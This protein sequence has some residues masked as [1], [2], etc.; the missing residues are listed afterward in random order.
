[1]TEGL[2]SGHPWSPD[3]DELRLGLRGHVAGELSLGVELGTALCGGY[4]L[5]AA[6]VSQ[7]L[8]VC[9]EPALAV[10]GCANAC[11]GDADEQY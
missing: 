10:R 5:D 11:R 1:V 6:G 4:A 9:R 2:L 3:R 7:L 8:P